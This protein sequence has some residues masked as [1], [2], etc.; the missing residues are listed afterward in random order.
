MALL[1]ALSLA[2]CARKHAA[3]PE[4]QSAESQGADLQPATSKNPYH[5]VMPQKIKDQVETIQKQ[6]E[7]RND[8]RIEQMKQ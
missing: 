4:A 1:L 6:E 8:R 2:G 3:K 7:D 5:D